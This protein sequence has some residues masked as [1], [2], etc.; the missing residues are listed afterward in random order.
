MPAAGPAAATAAASRA[1]PPPKQQASEVTSEEDA[2]ASLDGAIASGADAKLVRRTSMYTAASVSNSKLAASTITS[3]KAQA[4]LTA[5]AAQDQARETENFVAMRARMGTATNTGGQR[6]VRD[7]KYHFAAGSNMAVEVDMKQWYRLASRADDEKVL[8]MVKKEPLLARMHDPFFGYTALHWA[9]KFGKADLAR[10][11]LALGSDSNAQTKG[12]FTPLHFACAHGYH[13]IIKLLKERGANDLISDNAGRSPWEVMRQ[14][15][16]EVVTSIVHDPEGVKRAHA[17]AAAA[18]AQAKDGSFVPDPTGASFSKSLSV[19]ESHSGATI[20][21]RTSFTRTNMSG[22]IKPGGLSIQRSDDATG[23]HNNLAAPGTLHSG[24]GSTSNLHKPARRA[25]SMEQEGGHALK[26]GQ[27][28]KD[29]MET[30]FEDSNPVDMVQQRKNVLSGRAE[31]D[32]SPSSGLSTS[33]PNLAVASDARSRTG[34]T[35]ALSQSRERL[36]S[37]A[38][39]IGGSAT[40]PI[41]PQPDQAAEKAAAEQKAAEEKAAA[42]KKAADEKAAAEKKAAD[43]KAAAEKKAAD[44]K[45]AAEKAAAEKKAADEKAAAEKAKAAVATPSA[46]PEPSKD[47]AAKPATGTLSKTTSKTDANWMTQTSDYET[48]LQNKLEEELKKKAEAD[49]RRKASRVVAA[50]SSVELPE[51]AISWRGNRTR[52]KRNTD[53]N[54][55]KF[56]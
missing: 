8:E 48:Q 4:A 13:E 52:P 49:A 43:E 15:R 32:F 44:E 38:A 1:K 6:Q 7:K 40:P 10:R 9:V 51:D 26:K 23:S 41:T 30:S 5:A 54:A 22:V 45:A 16:Y 35:S 31:N 11:L 18:A 36:P 2:L 20:V 55:D 53:K 12:G 19:D 24:G 27:S 21:R 25:P 56:G 37:A 14:Q 42:E 46:T 47:A 50:Q 33:S 39:R 28:M 17:A 34:S 29:L 3:T